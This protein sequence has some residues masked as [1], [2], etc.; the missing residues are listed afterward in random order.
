MSDSSVHP[1][2]YPSPPHPTPGDSVNPCKIPLYQGKNSI[3]VSCC[4]FYSWSLTI[5]MPL[6]SHTT[7]LIYITT[8]YTKHTYSESHITRVMK[9]GTEFRILCGQVYM[10]ADNT[11]ILRNILVIFLPYS[12]FQTA[13]HLIRHLTYV[14]EFSLRVFMVNFVPK[15]TTP[16]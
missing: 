1:L 7:G 4:S 15:F 10:D 9:R 6:I 5:I 8:D 11:T 12:L 14:S 13:S 3:E 16:S 2:T